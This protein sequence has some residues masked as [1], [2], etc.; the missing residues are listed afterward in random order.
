MYVH[1][2]LIW[3]NSLTDLS[4][5]I[6]H[7]MSQS[8]Q[9]STWQNGNVQLVFVNKQWFNDCKQIM[10]HL[11]FLISDATT[12]T[13]WHMCSHYKQFIHTYICT[14]IRNTDTLSRVKINWKGEIYQDQGWGHPLVQVLEGAPPPYMH[15]ETAGDITTLHSQSQAI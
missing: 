12:L 5:Y 1:S 11:K 6:S 2:L 3:G 10:L 14:Y 7:C 13:I 4:N 8:M 15:S 9:P